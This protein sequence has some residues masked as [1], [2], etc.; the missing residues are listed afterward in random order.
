ML[1]KVGRSELAHWIETPTWQTLKTLVGTRITFIAKGR[2]EVDPLVSNDPWAQALK[3]QD[4]ASSSSRARPVDHQPAQVSLIPEVWTNEDG[5]IPQ[6]LDR[7]QNGS[8]GIVLVSPQQFL[9]DWQDTPLPLSA[10]E[11]LLIVW[12]PIQPPPAG[13]QFTPVTFPAR[14]LSVQPTITL[15][16]GQAFQFGAKEATLREEQDPKDFPQRS[17]VSLLI[18]AYKEEIPEQLWEEFLDNALAAV[19]RKLETVAPLLG[20]WGLRY[21][22]SKGKPVRPQEATKLSINILVEEGKLEGFLQKS[23]DPLWVNPRLDQPAFARFRPIWMPGTLE[24]VRIAHAKLAGAC[25]LVRTRRGFGV[26]VDSAR[27]E[28]CRRQLLPDAPQTPHLGRDS[29]LWHFKISPT[30]IGA[31]SDDIM[32]FLGKCIPNV[33]NTVKRQLGPRAWLVSFAAPI[34]V[35]YVHGKDG[36]VV[37]QPWHIGRKHDPLRNAIAVGNPRILKE[38]IATV[39]SAPAPARGPPAVTSSVIP[40]RSAQGPVQELLEAKI[41]ASEDRMKALLDEQKTIAESRHGEMRSRLDQHQ[42]CQE[43]RTKQLEETIQQHRS[44]TQLAVQ[45]L[46]E[47]SCQNHNRLERNMSEQF[48]AMLAELGKLTRSEAKRSPAPSPDGGNPEKQQKKN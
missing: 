34:Q 6:V 18:E 19:K 17:S 46:K 3:L 45:E 22:N 30:P 41:K 21:W 10:D 20:N 38:A 27:F 15:L 39:S 9:S 8:T 1:G 37:L 29:E 44:E 36:F 2:R 7:P 35:E 48:S 14:L 12:P 26:R 47:T 42:A 5:S 32:Q 23:G 13:T 40:P 31:T 16:H 28:E 43:L 33:K 4:P 24:Q 11:L 25:G